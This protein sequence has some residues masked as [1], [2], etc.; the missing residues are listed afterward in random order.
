[1]EELTDLLSRLSIQ[2]IDLSVDLIQEVLLKARLYK[3]LNKSDSIKWNKILDIL[4][5]HISVGLPRF[6]DHLLCTTCFYTVLSL[7]DNQEFY[8]ERVQTLIKFE[9]AARLSSPKALMKT[10]KTSLS[11]SLMYGMFQSSYLVKDSN[12]DVLHIKDILNETIDLLISM[13]YDYSRYTFLVYKTISSLSKVIG[14]KLQE[15]VYCKKNLN[16]LLN[17]INH[18]WENPITGVRDL[19]KIIFKTIVRLLNKDV[20]ESILQDI[21]SFQWNK[22]KYLMLS[23]IVEQP[24]HFINILNFIV[25]NNWTEGII[26]SLQK[27]GLVS[28]GADMYFAILKNLKSEEDWCTLFFNGLIDILKGSNSKAIENFCNYWCLT[29]FKKFPQLLQTLINE[30]LIC[31]KSDLIVYSNLCI[32]KQGNKL[33]LLNTKLISQKAYKEANMI[34]LTGLNH[35]DSSIRM[36]AFE[37]ISTTQGKDLSTESKCEIILKYLQNNINSDCTVLRMSML[38][39]FKYFI[40]KLSDSN[41]IN[42]EGK[43]NETEVFFRKVQEFIVQSLNLNGNYQRKITT[44][45]LCDIF[46]S[47]VNNKSRKKRKGKES[48]NVPAINQQRENDC[49]ILLEEEFVLNLFSHLKDPADDIRETTIQLIL[50]H[51][52]KIITPKFMDNLTKDAQ[53]SIQ[54]KFFFE[55]NCGQSTFKLLAS[56]LLKKSFNEYIFNNVDDIFIF[57]FNELHMEYEQK[58]NIV[59]SIEAGKQLH[60]LLGVLLQILKITKQN[61]YNLKS[62]KNIM[63]QLIQMSEDISTQFMWEEETSTSSDFSKMDEMIQN[64]II[65]SGYN[66]FDEKD[67]TKISGLQQIVLNCLWFNVKVSCDLISFVLQFLDDRQIEECKKCLSILTHVL[68]TSRHKGVIEAAGSALGRAI[69]YLT[70]LPDDSAFSQIPF[71]LLKRKLEELISYA[72][73]ASVTRRGAGLSIMVHRIVS[74]DMKKG[75]PLFHYFMETILHTCSDTKEIPNCLDESK[76][77]LPKAIYIHFLTRVVI[78]SSLASDMMYYSVELAEVAFDNLSST[79]WQIRNAALQLYGALIPKLIGQKKAMGTDN[80]TVASVACDEFRTHSP[81]LWQHMTECL[82]NVN[83]HEDIIQSHS[84]IMP[85]LNVLANLARRYNFSFDTTG[86]AC[87]KTILQNLIALLGSPIYTVRRLSAKCIYNIY[88]FEIIYK[89]VMLKEIKFENEIHGSLILIKICNTHYKSQKYQIQCEEIVNKYNCLLKERKHSY[90]CKQQ[91]E[92]LS[93]KD[94]VY[95][96]RETLQESKQNMHS[97]G[98][99]YWVDS[100]LKIYIQ[101]CS[102]EDLTAII[103]ILLEE[104][105]FNK[106]CVFILDKIRCNENVSKH[107]LAKI[108]TIILQSKHHSDSTMMWQILYEISLKVEVNCNELPRSIFIH[109]QKSTICYRIRYII[110][111]LAS[112]A[113]QLSYEHLLNLSEIIFKLCDPGTTDVDL[114]FIAALGNNEMGKQFASLKSSRIKITTIKSAI[115]LLQDE[116]EDIR[117]KS[118]DFYKH[119]S[120][121][122]TNLHPYVC[123]YK[124]LSKDYLQDILDNPQIEIPLLCDEIDGTLSSYT[125]KDVDYYNPFSNESKNIYFEIEVVRL[126]LNNLKSSYKK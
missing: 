20:Y 7:T 95:G 79:H 70:S 92:E 9:N 117:L 115:I 111:F 104:R 81:K 96:I 25:E 47:S 77:D 105:D 4:W 24:K 57:V 90:I 68:E 17:L 61:A 18:N 78:D 52:S 121:S 10:T 36:L 44:L 62:V 86:E 6:D 16:R 34:I 41:Q 38:N 106:Y 42:S 8:L 31:K 88:D 75:K 45:K 40:T 50:D 51:Y 116:D 98:V 23:E 73:M 21:N 63:P 19:N 32:L 91:I 29:T 26:S 120:D 126:Y 54:S 22:A 39:N 12:E 112:L 69:Q 53:K 109:L 100:R 74:S 58:R 119:T 76:T 124:I 123:T 102:W 113:R 125:K 66:P 64:I 67:S 49:L 55:I 110:P 60:S 71:S 107:I 15:I 85:V 97:P 11:V 65:A 83:M 118:A 1:M 87:Y 108:A 72:S 114:R 33:G 122:E 48:C 89:T 101:F 103:P 56:L 2:S 27:P 80:E 99:S 84:D 3:T 43:K 37:I 28:A 93:R 46:L 14:T 30:L 35:W 59:M 13:A 82:L 94:Q 5:N